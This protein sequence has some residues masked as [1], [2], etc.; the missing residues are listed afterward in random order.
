[1]EILSPLIIYPMPKP[2]PLVGP[3]PNNLKLGLPQ[4]LVL[5]IVLLILS[6]P[7]SE[8]MLG[9]FRGGFC[10]WSLADPEIELVSEKILECPLFG[11]LCS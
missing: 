2:S 9:T 3:N 1:M 6:H 11:G 8:K 10:P 7:G 4:L 5:R